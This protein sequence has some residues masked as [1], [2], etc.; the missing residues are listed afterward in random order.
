MAR[1]S[2][3]RARA[4]ASSA[5]AVPHAAAIRSAPGERLDAAAVPAPAQRTVGI[6]RLVADLA[7]RAVVAL[8]DPSINR[9]HPADARPERQPDHRGRATAGT[10][11]QLGKPERPSRR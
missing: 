10:E 6:D 11:P 4:T 8:V 1:A 2:P 9:D 5:V 7:G 3:A